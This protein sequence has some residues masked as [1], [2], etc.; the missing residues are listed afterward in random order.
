ML[1]QLLSLQAESVTRSLQSN[2]DL[3]HH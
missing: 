3:G 2:S 1:I